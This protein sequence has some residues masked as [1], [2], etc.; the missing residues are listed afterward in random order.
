[1][2]IPI[3]AAPPPPP[4]PPAEAPQAQNAMVANVSTT[5]EQIQTNSR[6][7]YVEASVGL[8]QEQT[9]APFFLPVSSRTG[10]LARV[11]TTIAPPFTRPVPHQENQNI[12][13]ENVTEYSL[14]NYVRATATTALR[15]EVSTTSTLRLISTITPENNNQQ[16]TSAIDSSFTVCAQLTQGL[17]SP[18]LNGSRILTPPPQTVPHINI[19]NQQDTGYS[20]ESSSLQVS[21]DVSVE[22]AATFE[23]HATQAAAVVGTTQLLASSIG[24]ALGAQILQPET[25][26]AIGGMVGQ[27]AGLAAMSLVSPPTLTLSRVFRS[28]L[29]ASSDFDYNL[30][31]GV[32][33]ASAAITFESRTPIIAEHEIDF[34]QPLPPPPPPQINFG[35]QNLDRG[36]RDGRDGISDRSGLR[37]R[38]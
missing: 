11:R 22:V 2:Q 21:S 36:D 15:S 1:M 38:R 32:A 12:V 6:A 16:P 23:E 24:A 3:P 5:T 33:S 27:A 34:D 29:T 28:S 20:P 26:A 17:A 19:L 31:G 14:S 37:R 13:V 10:T 7:F 25:G 4:P 9:V 8:A 30:Q 18:F 35:G